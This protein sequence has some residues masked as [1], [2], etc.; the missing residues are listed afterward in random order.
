MTDNLS[1]AARRR[2]MSAIRAKRTKL[3]DRV[4]K[5]LW[6]RG[7]RFRRNVSGLFGK[8]DI[9]I[10]KR[11]CVVFIDSC[12]WHGCPQHGNMPSTNTE[13]WRPKLARNIARDNEVTNYYL[14]NRWK[15]LRVW[16]HEV[17]DDFEAVVN[18][19]YTFLKD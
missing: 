17:K 15:I 12:F 7:L 6:R 19:L 11:K 14:N 3:E 8:P 5:A 10:Q 16:E 2:A 9:A 13:Y 4:T 18:R 1:E